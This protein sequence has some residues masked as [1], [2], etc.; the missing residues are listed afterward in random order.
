[1]SVN[2]NTNPNSSATSRIGITSGRVIWN[3]WRKN[4]APST[5]AASWMSWGIDES[6]PSRITVA[7]GS[8]RQ[9]CTVMID[10]IARYGWPSQ[11]GQVSRPE[12]ADVHAASS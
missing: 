4:P 7:S 1:M 6:P 3:R 11:I 12:D 10:A 2:A 8:V 9:T 5:S